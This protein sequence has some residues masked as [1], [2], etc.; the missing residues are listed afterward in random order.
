MGAMAADRNAPLLALA[1]GAAGGAAGFPAGARGAG[2]GAHHRR[3]MVVDARRHNLDATG[4]LV[5][6]EAVMMG[7]APAIDGAAHEA[8]HHACEVALAEGD[9]LAATGRDATVAA[10]HR[11]SRS[12]LLLTPPLSRARRPSSTGCWRRSDTA[13]MPGGGWEHCRN[14]SHA[15]CLSRLGAAAASAGAAG[16]RGRTMALRSAPDRRRQDAGRLPALPCRSCPL[17]A[18]GGCTPCMS[19]RSRRWP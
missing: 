1:G 19:R 16:C 18:A 17:P 5:M 8:V 9:P 2:T 4:G 15:G 13:A 6:A 14:R 11:P 7:L 12:P 10:A 3:G